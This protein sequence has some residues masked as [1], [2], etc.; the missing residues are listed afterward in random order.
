MATGASDGDIVVWDFEFGRLL[1]RC[2]RIVSTITHLAFVDPYPA[3]LSSDGSGTFH[4]WATPP[5]SDRFSCLAAWQTDRA[6]PKPETDPPGSHVPVNSSSIL[7]FTLAT[8][9][10]ESSASTLDAA[11]A[12]VGARATQGRTGASTV[13]VQLWRVSSDRGRVARP[14]GR[15]SSE[16]LSKRDGDTPLRVVWGHPSRGERDAE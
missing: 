1:G 13:T 2:E 15:P 14:S 11:L 8:Q 3:L 9:Y 7:C 16:T 5:S 10:E 12:D 4:L 6:S